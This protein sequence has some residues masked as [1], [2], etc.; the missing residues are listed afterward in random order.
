MKVRV[1]PIRWVLVA[2]AIAATTALAGCTSPNSGVITQSVE[3]AASPSTAASTSSTVDSSSTTTPPTDSLTTSS[4]PLPTED[5]GV[6]ASSWPSDFTPAQ[7]DAARLSLQVVA[8]FVAAVDEAEAAPAKKDWAADIR[9][10]S[11][12]PLA[13]QTLQGIQSM[14]QYNIHAESAIRYDQMMVVSADDHRV[15]VSTCMDSTT[16]VWLDP[17][18]ANVLD[19]PALPR[20]VKTF[21]LSAYDAQ[22]AP[23]GWLVFETSFTTPA[24]PC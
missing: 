9:R 12:D 3:T 14:A 23:E 18:G 20:Q 13:A 11:A 24:S 16:A 10:F 22:Y 5:T 8:G 2:A 21:V 17:S 1:G 15:A 19:A 7:Q 6:A 4:E